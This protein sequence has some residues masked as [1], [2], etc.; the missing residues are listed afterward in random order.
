[1]FIFGTGLGFAQTYSVLYNLGSKTGDPWNP[2]WSGIIAQG[3]DGNLYTTA[4]QDGDGSV[5]RITPAGA[6]TILHNF[7]GTDGLSPSGGLTLGTD[8]NFYGTTSGGGFAPGTIFNI[9]SSGTLATL[10]TF[11]NTTDGSAPTAPPIRGLDGNFYGTTSNG[12]GI[13]GTVYKL[14]SSGTFSV[15]HG[16]AFNDGGFPQAPLVQ[17]TD[18]SFYDTTEAASTDN[19]GTVFKITSTGT[20]TSL[21][22]FESTHGANPFAPLIQ[23]TD[24]N[25]YGTTR[26]GG[27]SNLGTVFK[28]T[29][30]G[31]ITVL[32][33]FAGTTDGPV[34][35]AVWFKRATETFMA[36]LL[37]RMELRDV[38]RSSASVLA[39]PSQLS[40][41]SLAMAQWAVIRRTH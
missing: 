35:L 12:N 28:I 2:T 1:L 8:G 36:P 37:W 9:S 21:F 13:F 32:H 38:A 20:F 29:S 24:G 40:L 17:G 19:L 5:F 22:S 3:R 27:S 33:N 31:T 6:L 16:F 41:R 34:L 14:S 10:Y 18:G 15:L 30:H 11:M 25:F 39:E 26:N 4:P 23:G 7:T